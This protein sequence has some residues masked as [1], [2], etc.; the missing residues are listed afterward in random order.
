MD[1]DLLIRGRLI[2]ANELQLTREIIKQH[3]AKGRSFISRELCRIW[4][5]RQPNGI[6]KDQVCRIL[7]RQLEQRD[8]IKLPPPLRGSTNKNRCYYVVPNPPPSFPQQPLEGMLKEFPSVRLKMV[9]RTVE[10]GLWNYLV[11]RYHYQSYKIIVGAHLKY[12]AFI[13]DVPI[14]CL[15][16]CSSLFRIH[17]RDQFLGWSREAK[18]EN[19]RFMANNSR[20]IILPW[21]RIKNLASHL[22]ALSVRELSQD[23]LSFYDHPLYLLETFVDTDR[24][25]GTCYRAANWIWVGQTKGYAKKGWFYY[26]GRK[27]GVYVYPLVDDYRD[28]LCSCKEKAGADELPES[29]TFLERFSYWKGTDGTFDQGFAKHL[30][31][32]T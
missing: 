8:L 21:V 23:W 7:L 29:S 9:R 14:A 2:T 20:F 27:K 26:H 1:Q 22:L 12:M 32:K 30:I 13:D 4:D 16:W 25:A 3:W 18:S 31:T 15:A 19:I 5:W 28:R 6:Y 10:E 11:Y 17:C 24:F